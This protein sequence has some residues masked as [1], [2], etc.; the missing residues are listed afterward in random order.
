MYVR[1][2]G[3]YEDYPKEHEEDCEESG[4]FRGGMEVPVTDGG[5]G[6]RDVVDRVDK[7]PAFPAYKVRQSEL[8]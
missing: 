1:T 2:H 3:Q 5:D 6:H 8:S 4:T 7:V